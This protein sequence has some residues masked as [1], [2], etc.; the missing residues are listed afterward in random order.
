MIKTS[1][2]ENPNTKLFKELKSSINEDFDDPKRSLYSLSSKKE[3]MQII[4][5]LSS[6]GYHYPRLV[7]PI[8]PRFQAE[9]PQWEDITNIRPCIDDDFKWFNC[10]IWSMPDIKESNIEGVGKGRH[11][12]CSCD[13]PR[14]VDCVKL[15]I[16]EARKLLQLE[17]G[18]TFSSWNF[19]EMGED[20]SKSWTLEE[21][22]EFDSLTRL[23]SLSDDMDF[24]KVAR[25]KFPFKSLKSMINYYYNVCIPKRISMETR[26]SFGIVDSDDDK[27]MDYKK[28][29]VDSTIGIHAVPIFNFR[30][31][32]YF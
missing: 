17:I 20:V 29:D 14:S 30:K 25:E 5:P 8:G 13:F 9:I 19:D 10:E 16:D 23:I 22:K 7:I 4:K 24:W 21:Q 12:T 11:Q 6:R 15:H 31:S 27:V 1:I 18:T 3:D 26:A 2:K 28:E 32:N